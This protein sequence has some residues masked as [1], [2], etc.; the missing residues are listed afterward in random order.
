MI[1]NDSWADGGRNNGADPLDTDWWTSTSSQA[2]EVSVGSLGLVSGTSGRGIHGTYPLQQLVNVGDTLTATYTFTTPSTVVASPGSQA[3]FRIGLFDGDPGLAAD[4]T[5][6]SGSPNPVY[7]S[8]AG[9]MYDFDVNFATANIQFRERSVAS[10]QMMAATADFTNLASGGSVY[11]FAANTSYTGVFSITRTASGVDMTGSLSQGST[12][13][14]TFTTSDNSGI[15]SSFD[16]LAFHVNSNVFGSSATPNTAN[17][18]IDFSNIQIEF[19]PVPEPAT[20]AMIG[21]AALMF[22]VHT[23][24][25]KS[26]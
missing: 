18:G 16:V 6:S 14:S 7:N 25:R 12:L 22:A 4:I 8:L 9:Y 5:A 3:A 20:L 10:G 26:R 24:R 17:N 23:G 21:M 15:T 19:I 11:S 1:V 13:L 2:I